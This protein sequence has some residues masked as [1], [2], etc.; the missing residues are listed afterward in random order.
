MLFFTG[1]QF[2]PGSVRE[3]RDFLGGIFA[4]MGVVLLIV[5][6]ILQVPAPPIVVQPQAGPPPEPPKPVEIEIKRTA[7][8]DLGAEPPAAA[9][10]SPQ[11]QLAAVDRRLAS[12]KVRYGLDE[13]SKEAYKRMAAELERERAEIEMFLDRER[14]GPGPASPTRNS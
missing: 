5:G 14:Q 8:W 7:M 3:D 1:D 12:L 13:I 4:T 11:E 2:L 6:A 10:L 9:E